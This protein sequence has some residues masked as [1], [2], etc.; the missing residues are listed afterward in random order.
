MATV[1]VVDD[2][3]QVRRL[4]LD[5][6]ADDHVCHAAESAEQA[7]DL[8]AS[9]NYDVV[10]TDISMPGEG[11][12][13][14]LNQLGR[15]HPDTPVIVITGNDY[16][17]HAGDLINMGAFDLLMKPFQAED[18]EEAVARAIAHRQQLLGGRRIDRRS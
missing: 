13:G 14:L 2:E 11:G 18:V 15:R 8:L 6:L 7:L 5:F 3:A 9:G 17:Q 16:E 4:L 12:I 10:V 1:L